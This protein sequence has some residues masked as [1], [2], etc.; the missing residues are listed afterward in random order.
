MASQSGSFWQ[1]LAGIFA[2][3]AT[4]E[5]EKKELEEEEDDI[6]EREDTLEEK[7]EKEV[8][9]V[10]DENYNE[11]QLVTKIQEGTWLFNDYYKCTVS[12]NPILTNICHDMKA[13]G[14]FAFIPN[15]SPA[16]PSVPNTDTS[17]STKRK[18]VLIIR[19]PYA[20]QTPSLIMFGQENHQLNSANLQPLVE[21]Y[22]GSSKVRDV[23][24]AETRHLSL[25][26]LE[27][28]PS[29]DEENDQPSIH[30]D[31]FEGYMDLIPPVFFIGFN[32]SRSE[33]IC[34]NMIYNIYFDLKEGLGAPTALEVSRVVNKIDTD[35]VWQLHSYDYHQE[36]QERYL[37]VAIIILGSITFMLNA[38]FTNDA[39][40]CF[41]TLQKFEFIENPQEK[42]IYF[43][44]VSKDA[45]LDL[46][47]IARKGDSK[48]NCAMPDAHNSRDSSVSSIDTIPSF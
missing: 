46:I 28:E 21:K 37:L 33:F 42:N 35:I 43:R 4:D 22:G 5:G 14:E 29:Y 41:E 31:F 12:S 27:C 25:K 8:R 3:S 16:E 40:N 24:L 30:Y 47:K 34:A 15:D 20:S 36:G 45:K 23:L 10:F 48:E 44:F 26:K 6:F 7:V 17:S 39:R 11:P 19:G 13:L 32:H 9:R 1:Y 38:I 2:N 18:P